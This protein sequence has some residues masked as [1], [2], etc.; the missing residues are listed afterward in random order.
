MTRPRSP[1]DMAALRTRAAIRLERRLRTSD[2]CPRCIALNRGARGALRSI[3]RAIGEMEDE[4]AAM[5]PDEMYDRSREA[6]ME[7]NMGRWA[8]GDR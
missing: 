4:A 5:D 1:E 6:A 8:H 7:E 2:G 3:D